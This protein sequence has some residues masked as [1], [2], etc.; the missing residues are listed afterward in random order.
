MSKVD[1]D[2][3]HAV[4]VGESGVGEDGKYRGGQSRLRR[5]AVRA[6]AF[7]PSRRLV[8]SLPD[9]RGELL[10]CGHTGPVLTVHVRGQGATALEPG[11]VP[12]RWVYRRCNKCRDGLP[13]DTR[14]DAS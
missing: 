5:R 8:W 13:F 7:G 4:A 14:G 12:L 6:E 11:T 1:H 2:G 10:E 9:G 3:V